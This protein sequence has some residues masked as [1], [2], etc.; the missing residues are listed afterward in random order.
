M[1][2]V[3]GTST[4][5][6]ANGNGFAA[7]CVQLSAASVN[8]HGRS[9]GHPVS[10]A[11]ARRIANLE[12]YLQKIVPVPEEWK[13]SA[14]PRPEHRDGNTSIYLIPLSPPTLAAEAYSGFVGDFL[15][16][17]A[18]YTEASDAGVVAHLLPAVGT[19]IGPGPHVWGGDEQPARVNT[20]LAGPT[21]TGRKGTSF[22]PVNL[23]MRETA[24][25][26]WNEQQ[27]RGL[28]SGEGLIQKVSDEKTKN[29]DG[30]WEI[31]PVEKRLYVVE[32]EFSRV[33]AQTRRDGNILSQILRETYDSG[34]LGVLTRNPLHAQDAHISIT[35]HITPEELKKRFSE[36][37]MA[38][39]FGN[40]FLWFAVRSD[41]ELP[42]ADP[43]PEKL[44]AKFAA[45]LRLI[46]RFAERQRRMKFDA[47]AKA[48]WKVVYSDLRKDRPGFAG[49]LT[50][51]GESIVLRVALIYALLDQSTSIKREHLESALAVWRYNVESVELL[52]R[53]KA[54][55]SLADTLYR[56]LGNGPMKTAEFHNHMNKPS[57]EIREALELL[58]HNERIRRTKVPHSGPGRPAELWERVD[59]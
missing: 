21:A 20:V 29:E 51:R 34:N 18:E 53:N 36:V 33:L 42:C 9:N 3:N 40:R 31:T 8:G 13:R 28:S 46:L 12:G 35:G 59:P 11:V 47:E 22:V 56:L 44:I 48:L 45:R 38:N 14:E 4:N 17:M 32:S 26:F 24:P 16:A 50:A 55:N 25:E 23:L 1:P 54:G 49:A 5:G 19:I 57:A 15:R 41:K 6:H 39:G 10:P 52:F 37:E 43:I 2:R 58:E 30:E 27:V 7:R